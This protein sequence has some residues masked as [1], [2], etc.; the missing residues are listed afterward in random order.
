M[1]SSQQHSSTFRRQ[2][3]L[4]YQSGA[5]STTAS[6]AGAN[7]QSSD[8]EYECDYSEFS[9]YLDTNPE[10][11]DR[12]DLD[13]SGGYAPA[14]GSSSR[15]QQLHLNQSM[16]NEDGALVSEGGPMAGYPQE[17]AKAL[18]GGQYNA[19]VRDGTM[20]AVGDG[21]PEAK[22]HATLEDHGNCT[23]FYACLSIALQTF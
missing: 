11:F 3:S 5:E 18:Q 6:T 13:G 22:I 2:T 21:R 7:R 8:A 14:G 17:T 10:D 23:A 20:Q 9:S 19:D 15:P 1:S 4:P 12:E 16:S